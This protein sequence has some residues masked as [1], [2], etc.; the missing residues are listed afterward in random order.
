MTRRSSRGVTWSSEI[1]SRNGWVARLIDHREGQQQRIQDRRIQHGSNYMPATSSLAR[2][3][4]L[5]FDILYRVL[6]LQQIINAQAA[7]GNR[8]QCEKEA[9]GGGMEKA[10]EAA[11]SENAR[12]GRR[13]ELV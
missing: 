4:I 9:S 6:C 10:R 2:R 11:P 7:T 1:S 8:Q 12:S 3:T 5:W 13:S